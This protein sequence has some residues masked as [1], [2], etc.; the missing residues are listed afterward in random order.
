MFWSSGEADGSC[1]WLVGTVKEDVEP[2]G[3]RSTGVTKDASKPNPATGKMAEKVEDVGPCEET[4]PKAE[5]STA[6]LL[7]RKRRTFRVTSL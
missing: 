4:S 7:E 3:W 1:L 2:A 5:M 6:L